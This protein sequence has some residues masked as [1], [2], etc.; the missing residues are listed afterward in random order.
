MSGGSILIVDDDEA[1]VEAVT[2][3]L[4]EYGYRIR[5]AHSGRQAVMEALRNPVSLAVV[6]VHLPDADGTDLAAWLRR[7]QPSTAVI[8]ISSDDSPETQ[9]RCAKVRP[10]LFMSKP[11][12]PETLLDTVLRVAGAAPQRTAGLTVPARP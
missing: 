1:F 2:I 5:K 12:I 8:L 9:R 7:Y 6:D 10:Y 11:L 3:Y 4:E